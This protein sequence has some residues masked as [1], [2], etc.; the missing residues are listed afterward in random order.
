MPFFLLTVFGILGLVFGSFG[1]VLIERMPKGLSCLG[2][3]RCL[4]CQRTLLWWEL[5]PLLSHLGLGGR[6]HA[7]EN[8]IAWWYAAV[9]FGS[10]CL[11]MVS[12][13][14]AR[15]LVKGI[16]LAMALWVL[17]IIAWID[18]HSQAIPNVLSMVLLLSV[19]GYAFLN[20]RIDLWAPLLSLGFFGS[21]WACSRG[22]VLG[23]GDILVTSI[24]TLLFVRWHGVLFAILGAYAVGAMVCITLLL[25]GLRRRRDRIAFMPFWFCGVLFSLLLSEDPLILRGML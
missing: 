1:T 14:L 17:W 3:S 25:L 15:D 5:F 20:G 12:L 6:C 11:F 22:K 7:C 24:S 18:A 8:R 10:A 23:S 9:E 21:Q 19:C 13:I 16:A 2:R 4:S